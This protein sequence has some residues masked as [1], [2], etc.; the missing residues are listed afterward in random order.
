MGDPCNYVYFVAKGEVE[1]SQRRKKQ[2]SRAFGS[3]NSKSW[4]GDLSDVSDQILSVGTSFSEATLWVYWVHEGTLVSCDTGSIVRLHHRIFHDII[5]MS[6]VI[7]EVLYHYAICFY[8]AFEGDRRWSDYI[9]YKELAVLLSCYEG[10]APAITAAQ[11]LRESP[12]FSRCARPSLVSC[13][14]NRTS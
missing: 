9:T 11:L 2:R 10:M 3:N 12:L 13:A 8:R 6:V 7:H 5:K 14:T 4:S 1:Y